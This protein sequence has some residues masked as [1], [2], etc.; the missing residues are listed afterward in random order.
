MNAVDGRNLDLNLLRVFVAVATAGGV[1]R[2]AARLYLT[3]SAVSAALARLQRTVDTP[4]F[5]RHGRGLALTA[6]GQTLLDNVRPHLEA[7]VRATLDPAAFRPESSDRT[8]R[9][10]LSDALVRWV[11]PPLLRTLR[12]KAPGMRIVVLPVQFRSAAEALTT[13]NVDVALT[14]ADDLPASIRRTPLFTTQFVC[15]FDPRHAKLRTPLRLR[16]YFAHEHVIVSYNGDLRGIVEDALGKTRRVRCSVNS[17]SELDAIV[18]GTPLLATVPAPVAAEARRLHPELRAAPLPFR[19][20]PPPVEM[21]WPAALDDDPA[22]A[23]LRT[24]VAEVVQR[25]LGRG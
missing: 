14:V 9:L 11:L 23:F 3:Q 8:F 13:G 1:T 15:L 10:G 5:A 6:R 17:F 21:L 2:A 24:N 4:L 7:L 12:G 20:N 25:A 18:V 22:L 16:D 19:L